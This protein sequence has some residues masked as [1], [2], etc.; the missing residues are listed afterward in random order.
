MTITTSSSGGPTSKWYKSYSFWTEHRWPLEI[1]SCLQADA[2]LLFPVQSYQLCKMGH[3]YTRKMNHLPDEVKAEFESGKSHLLWRGRSSSSTKLPR[4]RARSGWTA[5]G[6]RVVVSLVS[7]RHHQ[8]WAGGPCHSIWDHIW[9]V[10][11]SLWDRARQCI[12][13]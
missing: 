2:S 6:K 9:L 12:H 4:I 11:Q 3:L 5:S 8:L 13:S 10:R 7:W 1:S